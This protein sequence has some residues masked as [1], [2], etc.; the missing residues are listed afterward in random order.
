VS[1]TVAEA[2][3]VVDVVDMEDTVEVVEPETATKVSAPTAKS[4][5]ILQMHADNANALRREE[6]TEMMTA[7]AS[8]VRTQ[9]TSKLI[10]PPTN[11]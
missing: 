3:A 4:S 8:S 9:A 2:E 10:A 11:V 7:F 1:V 5:A 6:T